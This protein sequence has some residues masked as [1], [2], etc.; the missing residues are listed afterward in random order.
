MPVINRIAGFSE[1]MAEWRQH[2][3]R[4]PELGLECHKKRP[5]LSSTNS[6]SLGS[7][8]FTLGLPHPVL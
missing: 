5:S 3:H 4:N 7:R 2:M 1:E 6:K 8:I